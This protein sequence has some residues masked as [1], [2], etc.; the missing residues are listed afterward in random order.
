MSNKIKRVR[1]DRDGCF[2]SLKPGNR[3]MKRY[4]KKYARSRA[5]KER[6]RL[7]NWTEALSADNRYR[8][9][10]ALRGWE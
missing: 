5:D 3:G 4:G 2:R 9:E 6:E 7:T 10:D 1:D 8:R